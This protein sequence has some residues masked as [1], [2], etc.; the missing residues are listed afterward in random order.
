MGGERG[1]GEKWKGW[2]GEIEKRGG[3]VERR[4]GRDEEE[5]RRCG[6]DM[7]GMG[8]V[9]RDARRVDKRKQAYNHTNVCG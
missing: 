7:R 3:R 8:G 9:E 2:R 5:E 4:G 1:G 6:G